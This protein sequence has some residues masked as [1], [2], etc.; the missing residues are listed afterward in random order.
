MDSNYL[1]ELIIIAGPN[2]AGKSTTSEDLLLD[3]GIHSFDFDKEFYS[4]WSK[5]GY[6]PLV[7]NGIKESVG[8]LFEERKQEAISSRSSFSFETNYNSNE[9]LKTVTEF[10]DAGFSIEL[11]FIILESPEIAI[12]RVNDRVLKGGHYVD[13]ETIRRRFHDGLALLDS[14]YLRFDVISTYVSR[15][16]Q[17]SSSVL[18]EPVGSTVELFNPI[19]EPILTYLPKLKSYLH[20]KT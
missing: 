1:P 15:T 2:G 7:E 17:I 13:K 19:P 9:I 16:N 11:I 12:D 4:S 20:N 18:I 5:F 6:D 8:K 14:T 3:V 10:K